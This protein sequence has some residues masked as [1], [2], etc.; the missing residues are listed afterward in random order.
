MKD[1]LEK[2]LLLVLEVFKNNYG[3][4]LNQEIVKE[5]FEKILEN[6]LY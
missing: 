2:Q 6:N 3:Q 4:E 5:V 1:Y